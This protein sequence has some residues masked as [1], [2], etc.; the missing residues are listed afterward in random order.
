VK[1]EVEVDDAVTP[2]NETVIRVQYEGEDD[3]LVDSGAGCGTAGRPGC[4]ISVRAGQRYH[5]GCSRP[6]IQTRRELRG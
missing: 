5:F 4:L 2:V 3:E 6:Q 1:V